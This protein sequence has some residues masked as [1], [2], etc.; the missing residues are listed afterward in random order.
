MGGFGGGGGEGGGASSYVSFTPFRSR[1]DA[2]RSDITFLSVDL[3][4]PPSHFYEGVFVCLCREGD[5]MDAIEPSLNHQ[6][7]GS[8]RETAC[9]YSMHLVGWL[10][11]VAG[12]MIVR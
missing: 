2:G 7:C 12:S 8:L 3:K 1:N 5:L 6:N 11:A 4:R 9:S 10:D